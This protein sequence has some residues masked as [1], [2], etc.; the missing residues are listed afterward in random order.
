[1]G[2]QLIQCRL[3]GFVLW[4]LE[5]CSCMFVLYFVF[6][7]FLQLPSTHL[8]RS[9]HAPPHLRIGLYEIN[10]ASVFCSGRC[11]ARAI[12][13]VGAQL[14]FTWMHLCIA[15]QPHILRAKHRLPERRCG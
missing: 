10:R 1:M 11:A 7:C 12:N 15:Q 13:L 3:S 8:I 9:A 5:G 6:A 2:D 14:A 4:L